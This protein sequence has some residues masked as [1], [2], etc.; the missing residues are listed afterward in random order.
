MCRH[1]DDRELDQIAE[2]FADLTGQLKDAAAIAVIGQS[3]NI[4]NPVTVQLTC[5][6]QKQLNTCD[7]ILKHIETRLQS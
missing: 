7:D 5:K 3:S 1:M 4:S 6:Q 2:L